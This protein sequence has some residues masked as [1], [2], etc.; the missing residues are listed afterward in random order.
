MRAMLFDRDDTLIVDEPYL[1]DPK[2]VRPVPGAGQAL[3]T[4]R[5]AGVPLG[6]VSN[7]PGGCVFVGDIGSDMDAARAAGARGIL[8]HTARTRHT[9][10]EAAPC[11]AR[12]LAD[13]VALAPGD[14]A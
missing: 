10:I 5:A 14:R 2:L 13:A 9:E 6:V 12:D 4:L 7:Q 8:V 1:A 11:V 3:K